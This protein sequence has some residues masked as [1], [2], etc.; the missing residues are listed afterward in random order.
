[1]VNLFLTCICSVY[2]WR[3][4]CYKGNTVQMHTCTLSPVGSPRGPNPEASG[5]A[6]C[7]SVSAASGAWRTPAAQGPEESQSYPPWAQ[8]AQQRP[9]V[10]QGTDAHWQQGWGASEHSPDFHQPDLKTN[11]IAMIRRHI[12]FILTKKYLYNQ[13]F[14][15][16]VDAGTYNQG[17]LSAVKKIQEL[18]S[19]CT[20]IVPSLLYCHL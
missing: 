2:A 19:K 12:A 15:H 8:A 4:Q 13:Y 18:C 17:F 6:W 9:E 3:D 7:G 11:S 14:L 10:V 20:I 1:M 5:L 16:I